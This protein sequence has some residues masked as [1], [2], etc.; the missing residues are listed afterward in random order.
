MLVT[1]DGKVY[2]FGDG[3]NGQLGHGTLQLQCSQPQQVPLL[4]EKIKH[5][6][7]GENHTALISGIY[8][9]DSKY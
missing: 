5:A 1:E 6:F 3:N 8:V 2:S 9:N 4:K 7:C